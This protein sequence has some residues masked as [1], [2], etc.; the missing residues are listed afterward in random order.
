MATPSE[1]LADALEVL[2]KIQ[3]NGAVAIRSAD[4]SRTYRER[5]IHHGFLQEV[6]KG[7]YIPARPDE[8]LG[9]TTAWYAAFWPF[10]SAYLN[11]LKGD[12]W[13]LSP[14]AS[15]ALHTGNLT[16]PDQ[17][18]VRATKARNN[19]T[20]LLHG[21][22]LLDIR[23]PLP[24][25]ADITVMDGL[26]LYSL[27]AALVSC[28]SQSF[29]Q[30]PMDMRAAL[31][32]ISDA[33]EVLRLLLKGGHSVVA[34]R[35]AGA[36]RNIGREAIADD[37]R[38]AMRAAGYNLR[39]TD[40]FAAPSRLQFTRRELSPYVNRIR[41]MWQDMREVVVRC[42]PPPP[43]NAL[44]KAAY[45]DHI[46]DVY[47]AD[48]YHSLSIEG[49]RVTPDLVDRV[50]SGKWSPARYAE[51][52]DSLAALA[53]RGYW[54]AHQAVLRSIEHIID[55]GNAGEIV[56]RDHGEWYRELF[57]PGVAAGIHS[58]ADLAGYRNAPVFI[59]GS[60]HTPPS[61]EAVR[62]AMPAFFELL[63]R[64]DNAAVRVVLGH[65][66]FVF[67]HPYLDGNG[68]IG[69]FLMNAM[70]A[71]GGYPWT[72]IPVERRADYLAA[73]EIASTRHDIEPFA[74]FLGSLV[75]HPSA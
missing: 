55:G 53:A 39:E 27:P 30:N 23:A 4:I 51:D 22:S 28:S 7:W 70:L 1:K 20:P 2:Q 48:A 15:I 75:E 59:R 66:I 25:P 68:R 10:C 35:L 65:Y 32:M 3:L 67:I 43:Q 52:K 49:Y 34:G 37:I 64:E 31:A 56:D 50:R 17:L 29:R 41:L 5:L 21:T 13:C 11:H 54:Q 42:F 45:L 73:L 60:K 62:D 38:D 71:S 18:L 58:P 8:P 16:V 33:S 72:I 26:R 61:K 6:I 40:P 44:S 47:V 19:V 69:R 24:D 74:R 14:E 9:E 12:A 46:A 57:G 63:A 36:F